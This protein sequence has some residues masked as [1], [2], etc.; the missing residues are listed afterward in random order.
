MGLR[1]ITFDG[2]LHC[3][4]ACFIVS[5]VGTCKH[6]LSIVDVKRVDT[7]RAKW[8]SGTFVVFLNEIS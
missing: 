7:G 2:T 5:F 4:K 8:S 1:A 6:Q 3:S